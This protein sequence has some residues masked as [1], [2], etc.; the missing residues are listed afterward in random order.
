[1][2]TPINFTKFITYT[3]KEVI[4]QMNENR[5]YLIENTSGNSKCWEPF[6]LAKGKLQ[7]NNIWY[8]ICK[9]S[10]SSIRYMNISPDNLPLPISTNNM[11]SHM[12]NVTKHIINL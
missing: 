6:N 1:M 7:I 12:K 4:T 2:P 5:L 10:H 9:K 8:C 11:L 3:P